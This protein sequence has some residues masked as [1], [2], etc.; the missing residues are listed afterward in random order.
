[1][2]RALPGV[3]L[4]GGVPE[5]RGRCPGVPERKV[6]AGDGPDPGRDDESFVILVNTGEF[7]DFRIDIAR[8]GITCIEEVSEKYHIE[9]GKTIEDIIE[10]LTIQM[11]KHA[12]KMEFEKAAYIRDKIILKVIYAD[13]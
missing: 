2:R 4:P 13:K 5:E 9:E 10:E 8:F 1:M 3:Y 6:R 12:E 11:L 7:S